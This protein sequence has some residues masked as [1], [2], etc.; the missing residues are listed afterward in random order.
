MTI[1]AISADC[2]ARISTRDGLGVNTFPVRQ[3][4][5][6]GDSAPL[7]DRLIAVTTTAGFSNIRSANGGARVAGWEDGGHVAIF[8]VAVKTGSSFRSIA[9]GEGVE[10][11]IVITV[12]F[13]VKESTAKIGKGFTGS[14][15][16]LA[17]ENRLAGGCV[18]GVLIC[19]GN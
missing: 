14:V 17:L 11:V 19:G 12:W 15:T 5:L 4:R 16:T 10:T 6:I 3:K 1:V 8:R 2:R 7:H 13:S 18:Y 9:N